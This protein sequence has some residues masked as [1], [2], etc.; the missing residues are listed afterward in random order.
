MSA[1]VFLLPPA[2]TPAKAKPH[3]LASQSSPTCCFSV[4]NS[5]TDVT[6]PSICKSHVAYGPQL[7]VSCTRPLSTRTKPSAQPNAIHDAS[8]AGSTSVST[9]STG[10]A[11]AANSGKKLANCSLESRTHCLQAHIDQSLFYCVSNQNDSIE[12]VTSCEE[13]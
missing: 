12:F 2:L 13:S 6:G 10:R 3:L 5:E 9:A 7:Q 1:C 11:N 8:L 4:A